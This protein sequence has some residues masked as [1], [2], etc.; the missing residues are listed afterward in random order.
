[1]EPKS[2][3]DLLAEYAKK[4]GDKPTILHIPQAK[5]ITLIQEALES[6]TPIPDPDIPDG[7][8]I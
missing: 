3:S 4:F 5:A 2:L 8:L 6:E 1:M 7:A